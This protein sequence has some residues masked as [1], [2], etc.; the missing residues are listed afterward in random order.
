MRSGDVC[1]HSPIRGSLLVTQSPTVLLRCSRSP[2][3]LLA[4]SRRCVQLA[5]SR[6]GNGENSASAEIL[7]ASAREVSPW[8]GGEVA[9]DLDRPV[10]M[11]IMHGHFN[12]NLAKSPPKLAP[13]TG[14]ALVVVTDPETGELLSWLL[15]SG[16]ELLPLPAPARAVDLDAVS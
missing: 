12:G 2:R 15:G 11:V 13:P 7:Y 3:M 16:A 1:S 9:D 14:D 5:R 8:F 10:A 6:K 4:T